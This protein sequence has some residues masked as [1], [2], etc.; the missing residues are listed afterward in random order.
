MKDKL[1]IVAI[2]NAFKQHH[3]TCVQHANDVK[4]RPWLYGYPR[5]VTKWNIYTGKITEFIYYELAKLLGVECSIPDVQPHENGDGGVDCLTEHGLTSVKF[6]SDLKDI[7]R[8]SEVLND[9]VYWCVKKL[10]NEKCDRMFIAVRYTTPRFMQIRDM[11]NNYMQFDE[12]SDELKMLFYKMF[13]EDVSYVIYDKHSEE[14][15]IIHL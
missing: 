12:N 15:R 5:D 1:L 2:I 9:K 4:K 11:T 10:M 14:V 7:A 13:L 6:T 3:I 8:N